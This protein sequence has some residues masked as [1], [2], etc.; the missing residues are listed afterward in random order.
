MILLNSK[1]PCLSSPYA[2]SKLRKAFQAKIFTGAFYKQRN[3]RLTLTALFS[4]A[5]K[6][7]TFMGR[8]WNTTVCKGPNTVPAMLSAHHLSVVGRPWAMAPHDPVA[9]KTTAGQIPALRKILLH[10]VLA[11]CRRRLEPRGVSLS[12]KSHGKLSCSQSWNTKAQKLTLQTKD[13]DNHDPGMH[14]QLTISF[15]HY[16]TSI[17]KMEQKHY[18]AGDCPRL[19][20]LRCVSDSLSSY[21]FSSLKQ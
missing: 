19:K 9:S 18:I 14:H 2:Q 4:S 7:A 20:C 10:F 5:A 16:F 8:Q 15:A 12:T 6:R 13:C 11:S 17:G 3:L 1:G 21:F